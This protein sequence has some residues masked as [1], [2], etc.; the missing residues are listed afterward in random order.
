MLGFHRLGIKGRTIAGCA[1]LLL[2]TVCALSSALI[3]Q[4]YR[5]GCKA[6]DQYVSNQARSVAYS[7]EPY[8]LL[9]DQEALRSVVHAVSSDETL[10]AAMIVD[11]K[12]QVLST[13]RPNAEARPES[14]IDLRRPIPGQILSDTV[15]VDRLPNQLLVVAPIWSGTSDI[16]VDM[17]DVAD[18]ASGTAPKRVVGYTV[19]MYG[20]DRV[21]SQ[22]ASALLSTLI[23]AGGVLTAGMLGTVVIV[24]QFLKPIGNLVRTVKAI[25]EGDLTQR[26][27]PVAVYEIGILA[28]AFNRMADFLSHYTQDLEEQ[29]RVRTSELQASETEARRLALAAEAASRAKSEFLANMSHEIRTPMTAILGFADS[30]DSGL[31]ELERREAICTIRRNGEHLLQ[32]VNDILDI[33]KIEAGK[34]VLEPLA[35]SPCQI[36]AEVA[37][38]MRVR[39]EGKGLHFEV[40][41]LGRMPETIR[42]DPTRLRQV[43]MNLVSN[44]IKFTEQGSIRL[45]VELSPEDAAGPMIEFHVIDSGLGMNAEQVASLF[46]PFTQVDTSFTRRFGGTGLGLAISK[47]ITDLM[48][49]EI[50]VKSS[51]GVGSTF[52]VR[53]PTGP[54]NGVALVDLPAESLVPQGGA[55]KLAAPTTEARLTCRILLVED[56]PDNQRLM[57]F[58]L[59]RAGAEVD[60]A[61][62][63]RVGVEKALA[64]RAEH[65]PYDVILMDMQ[66]PVLDGYGAT[67]LLRQQGYTQPI[68]ALTAHAMAGDRDKCVEAGCDDYT[69]KPINRQA[70]FELIKKHAPHVAITTAPPPPCKPAPLVSELAGD[71]DL[72]DLV[73]AF[74]SELPARIEAIQKALTVQEGKQLRVLAHQLKGAAGGYGFPTI[75]EA[76][77]ALELSVKSQAG[78]DE[79]KTRID[80]LAQLCN[81]AS[82]GSPSDGQPSSNSGQQSVS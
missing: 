46:R 49:G 65:R 32:I 55:P 72:A 17:P 38:S 48:G 53:V 71:P 64:A 73:S 2:V 40:D 29:V 26:A 79:I 31:T 76:A 67:R 44:A 12:G 22:L 30:L 60:V 47:R 66:M 20:L 33:S 50:R 59:K 41:Y 80:S 70:L 36:I 82:A 6:L 56:G 39:A 77:K 75:T 25:E 54:L 43:L 51:P 81:R 9:N 42:T 35:C 15:R 1:L 27:S 74:V 69:T 28:R 5:H 58:V 24:R 8:V 16:K 78:L 4:D 34:M 3:W 57:V 23:I 45:R 68:I 21:R 18:G 61:E 13:V 7:A 37:S 11:V 10:Q 14:I 19:L 63:G 62:N 52:T